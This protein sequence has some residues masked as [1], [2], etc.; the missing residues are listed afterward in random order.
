MFFS[1]DA[2]QQTANW[3]QVKFFAARIQRLSGS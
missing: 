3:S 2:K 1:D